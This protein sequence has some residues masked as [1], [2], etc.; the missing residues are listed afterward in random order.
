MAEDRSYNADEELAEGLCVA[1]TATGVS[2]T[3]LSADSPVFGIVQEKTLIGLA[4]PIRRDG[5]SKIV[6]GSGGLAVGDVV[7]CDTD[8]K[9]VADG[10]A[11]YGIG[12][13]SVAADEDNFARVDM[14]YPGITPA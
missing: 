14:G 6:A 5:E 4:A 13:C 8:G 2:A 10:G 1:R 7:V 12:W 3:A 11:A 9:G